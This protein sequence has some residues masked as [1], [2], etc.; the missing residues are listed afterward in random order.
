M[1]KKRN[2]RTERDALHNTIRV[3]TS[4]F[5][6]SGNDIPRSRGRAALRIVDTVP[7]SAGPIQ[8]SQAPAV[9]RP[10]RLAA[11]ADLE[12]AMPAIRSP[13]TETQHNE[14]HLKASQNI[15]Q[16]TPDAARVG[17]LRV[18]V[19]LKKV[20]PIGSKPSTKTKG[21]V[22]RGVSP[23]SWG[24]LGAKPLPVREARHLPEA[25]RTVSDDVR[26]STAAK[27][28]SSTPLRDGPTCKPR[29]HPRAGMG[30][31]REF[32]PWCDVKKR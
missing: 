10:S 6:K 19:P 2:H 11:L 26:P 17:N 9:Y 21:G 31:S 25:K 7:K 5:E 15:T 24:S 14:A 30:T 3:A 20:D 27:H 18:S 16:N 23:R 8:K 1:S 13:R 4:P 28:E 22:E 29:P 32:I 12:A